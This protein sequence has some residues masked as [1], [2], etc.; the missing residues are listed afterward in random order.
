MYG[1]AGRT[2]FDDTGTVIIMTSR[3][4]IPF[5]ILLVTPH[6]QQPNLRQNTKEPSPSH[7]KP[8]MNTPLSNTF[9]VLNV[10]EEDD[11]GPS[12]KETVQVDG[13]DQNP[14]VSEPIGNGISNVDADKVQDEERV[15]GHNDAYISSV[16]GGFTMD[17][18][19]LD[20][21]DGYEAQVYDLPEKM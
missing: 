18:D 1:R 21:Y 5:L 16:G 7:A 13:N 17:E 10:V 19:D 15:F 14:N 3:E 4:T 2:P 20:Y 8:G 11:C 9:D 12:D 6:Q